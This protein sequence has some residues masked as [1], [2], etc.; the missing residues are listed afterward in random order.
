MFGL[1]NLSRH[2]NE[3]WHEAGLGWVLLDQR[4]FP[5]TPVKSQDQRRPPF[6]LL[7]LRPKTNIEPETVAFDATALEHWFCSTF[8]AT[9][10]DHWFCSI[11][12]A[13]ALDY[14]FLF[15]TIAIFL[16]WELFRSGSVMPHPYGS[17]FLKEYIMKNYKSNLP[18]GE[19]WDN[20]KMYLDGNMYLL[21]RRKA[22]VDN[23]R[24]G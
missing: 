24:S 15:N 22:G 2:G 12:D 3:V 16:P 8:D 6:H 1:M 7:W 9:A 20:F 21:L 11:F 4:P 19:R 18:S 23:A 13:T 5:S 10:V 14:W 17:K